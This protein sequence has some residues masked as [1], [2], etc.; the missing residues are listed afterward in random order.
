MK[1]RQQNRKTGSKLKIVRT[2]DGSHTIGLENV[3]EHY[4]ST[5]GALTESRHVFVKAGFDAAAQRFGEISLLE[6][7]FGTGLNCLLTLIR[8]EQQRV[9]LSYTGIE[10]MPLS[11]QLL[12]GLNY[13]EIISDQSSHRWWNFI[14]YGS[15]WNSRTNSGTE[16]SL[17]KWEGRFEEFHAEGSLYNLVYFDAFAPD[18]QPELW[19][20]E[21]FQK[22]ATMMADGGILVTYSSKG[23]VRRALAEAGFTVQ[24]I[25]GPS[26]KREM[27]RAVY[28]GNNS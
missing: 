16:I 23:I 22:L 13:P 6:V 4:H 10:P 27:V 11:D 12:S 2:D 3:D 5:F 8:A 15:Q 25:P 26:G 17:L 9:K 28:N 24:K 7:G 14:N 20:S 21:V 1:S 18:V 19:R